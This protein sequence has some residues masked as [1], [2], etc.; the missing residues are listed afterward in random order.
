MLA[1]STIAQPLMTALASCFEEGLRRVG[2]RGART[3]APPSGR[4][5]TVYA[6]PGAGDRKQPPSSRAP[7]MPS[8]TAR[9]VLSGLLLS[10]LCA[11]LGGAC[12]DTPPL[13][14]YYRCAD[15]T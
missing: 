3:E 13:D 11:A 15:D 2:C 14:G 9:L 10:G 1:S 7:P 12:Y 5:R 8:P 6:G 4:S